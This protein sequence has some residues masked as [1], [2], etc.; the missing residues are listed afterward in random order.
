MNKNSNK[1]T[2]TTVFI[3]T[4]HIVTQQDRDDDDKD[5]NENDNDDDD[6]DDDNNNINIYSNQIY[7]NP[8]GQ[9]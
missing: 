5:N 2:L 4:K 8:T 6:D 3:V 7:S 1:L 9:R